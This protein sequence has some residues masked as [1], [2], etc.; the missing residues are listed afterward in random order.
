[1]LIELD[2]RELTLDPELAGVARRC[3]W[4]TEP[5][6]AL[7]DLRLFLCHVMVYGLWQDALIIRRRFTSDQLAD[8]LVH[9]PAGLFDVRSWHYWHNV[10]ALPVAPLPRRRIPGSEAVG[11]TSKLDFH[12]GRS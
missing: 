3:L 5:A 9:A 11:A 12:Q 10:L 2:S 6:Q 8:A 7:A 4:W 1:M